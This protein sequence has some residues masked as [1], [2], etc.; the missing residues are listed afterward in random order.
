MAK[1]R[2]KHQ[3]DLYQSYKASNRFA[4]NRKRKLT[5]LLKQFPNNEQIAQALK[6]I[7][8]RRH[9]PN[10]PILTA[11]K[12]R[13]QK[14]VKLFTKGTYNVEKMTEKTMFQL[15]TR[16]NVGIKWSI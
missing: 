14:L 7:T 8:Y 4:T 3:K 15:K 11:T 5:K 10:N 13:M 12:R 16:A 9:T 1:T 6:N 2:S